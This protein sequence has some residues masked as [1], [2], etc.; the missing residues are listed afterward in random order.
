MTPR[1]LP[2]QLEVTPDLPP[3]RSE[4]GV[5]G[6][7]ANNARAGATPVALVGGGRSVAASG[8]PDQRIATLGDAQ[9]GRASR[10]QLLAGGLTPWMIRARIRRGTLLRTRHP[11]I[12]AVGHASSTELSAE[13]EA[14]LACGPGAVL[15]HLTAA[16]LHGLLPDRPPEV[17]VTMLRGKHAASRPGIVVH[18]TR[19][20]S[21]PDVGR[22][23]GLAVTTAAR[24]MIDLAD[25]STKRVVERAF[26]EAIARRLV[27]P[28][29]MREAI[30]RA[31][32]RRGNPF[33]VALLDPDRARGVTR[34]RAEERLLGLL[35][36]AGIP[37]PQRNVPVGPF[38]V[39]FLWPKQAVAIEVDS[40]TWHAGPSV[41]KRDRRKDAY[42]ADRGVRLLRVT[43]EM[44]DEPL[45]LIARIVRTHAQ[46]PPAL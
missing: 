6:R 23:R 5:A 11:G 1:R 12:Y 25:S 16:A 29:K 4:E 42:L 22:H 10:A 2:P 14:L 40:Y 37:D 7:G 27:S 36:A 44:M 24:A 26:D 35:R 38:V 13:V 33:L 32:G 15:S 20:L 43:W 45:P 39:D 46:P 28:T 18:R 9:E 21:R 30:A 17:H 31:P 3:P 8:T 41:F 19:S 34:S